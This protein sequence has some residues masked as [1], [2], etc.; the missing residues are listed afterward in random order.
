MNDN[1]DAIIVGAGPAGLAAAAELAKHQLSVCL[2]DE[3]IGPG[4]QIWRN[5]NPTHMW[6][7]VIYNP[8][9]TVI[10]ISAQET[11]NVTWLQHSPDGKVMRETP[12]HALI[13]ATGAM[14]RP[15]LFPGVQLPGVMGVGAVQSVLKQARMVPRGPG[16][17][18][19]GHGPLLLLTAKQIME[20]GASIDAVLDLSIPG[21]RQNAAKY[22][23]RALM[24]DPS[25]LLQG[26]QLIRGL[27]RMG[28]RVWKNVTDLQ[29]TGD[30]H[31]EQVQFFANGSQQSL[32]A[33]LL[34]VHDGVLPNTQLT[35]LLNLEHR[36]NEAQQS[37]APLTQADGQ[38]SHPRVWIAGDGAGIAGVDLAVQRGQLTGLVVAQALKSSPT[39]TTKQPDNANAKRLE[40]DISRRL[41]ARHFIDT[42]YPPLPVDYIATADTIVCRCEAITLG[43]IRSA[44]AQGAV[45]P[46]RVKTFTRCGMGACQG[47]QCSTQLTRIVAQ[48][49]GRP[50]GVVGALRIRP[51]LKPTLIADYLNM[52][53]TVIQNVDTTA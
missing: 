43:T 31:L 19:A 27:R 8:A 6:P 39:H 38:S 37:F 49:T 41:P 9:S 28:I 1:V 33:R 29:A 22:L 46:N 35:R 36:W 40:R 52:P 25:L 18:L 48:E 7:G 42:L 4:G 2:L 14:E 11:I 23:P 13:I 44:I 26:I 20:Q 15:L 30:G 53:L 34:A 16:V 51:P 50:A 17:L 10:D 32:P 5:T 24:A 21:A 3:Q 12:A 47:R 45:G